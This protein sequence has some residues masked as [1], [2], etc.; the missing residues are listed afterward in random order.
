MAITLQPYDAQHLPFSTVRF[1]KKDTAFQ[2]DVQIPRD[3]QYLKPKTPVQVGPLPAVDKKDA[4]AAKKDSTA[5]KKDSAAAAKQSPDEVDNDVDTDE[6]QQQQGQRGQQQGQQQGQRGQAGRG[7]AAATPPRPRTL[8]FEYDMAAGTL[9][10]IDEDYRA[11]QRPRWAQLSPD[12]KTIIFARTHNLFMMDAETYALAQKKA[13]DPKI[14]ET[15][16]TKDGEENYSF[17]RTVQAGGQIEQQQQD[18][19]QTG[20]EQET[21][22][23]N[24]RVPA[25]AAV[26]SRDSGK[27]SVVRRDQRKVADLWVINAL[28]TP[29]PKLEILP[30]RH[31]R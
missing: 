4:G 21:T 29:R 8:H 7:G 22:D 30:L 28:A 18:E 3:A 26:W 13:D 1:V 19:D 2:F 31:A 24:A 5:V 11:P 9:D 25:V 10:L 27:F 17:A 6:A 23:K 14:V 15:Q 12:G 20:T 16:L